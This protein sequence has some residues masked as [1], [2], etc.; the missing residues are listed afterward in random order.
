MHGYS[1]F[2]RR[3]IWTRKESQI[4]GTG[5]HRINITDGSKKL[6][7]LNGNQQPSIVSNLTIINLTEADAG[8]YTCSVKAD[9]CD[10]ED[11]TVESDILLLV[12]PNEPG[13][14]TRALMC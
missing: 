2:P 11:C 7:H 3:P 4:F 14:N 13:K 12:M 8:N 6:I 9:L 10:A 1:N 5:R